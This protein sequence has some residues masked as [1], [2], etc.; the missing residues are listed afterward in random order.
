VLFNSLLINVSTVN[1][2]ELVTS[3][4]PTGAAPSEGRVDFGHFVSA[5]VHDVLPTRELMRDPRTLL[6][7]PDRWLWDVSGFIDWT[8]AAAASE[9][10]WPLASR[11]VGASEAHR[12]AFR[13]G[14][15]AGRAGEPVDPMNGLAT[16]GLQ[17]ATLEKVHELGAAPDWL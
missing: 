8:V 12:Q 14:L 13:R 10:A 11:S 6:Q 7:L 4:T 9:Q 2:V 5:L 17:M 15:Q 1:T 3:A 16:L